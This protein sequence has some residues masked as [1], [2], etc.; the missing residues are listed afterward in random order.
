[1]T[2]RVSDLMVDVLS[3]DCPQP[4]KP[5]C[6]GHSNCP[7]PSKPHCPEPSKTQCPEPSKPTGKRDVSPLDGLASLRRQLRYEVRAQ[8]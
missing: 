6:Q 3:A 8:A 2:F 5:P 7:E 4:S 1:M